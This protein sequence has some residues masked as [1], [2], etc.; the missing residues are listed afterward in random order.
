[1]CLDPAALIDGTA[2]ARKI[3]E[4]MRATGERFGVAHIV[5]VLEGKPNDK[6][7]ALRHTA[8]V[9]FGLGKDR[10]RGEWQALIRQ[11]VGGGFVSLD[12]AGFGGLSIAPKGRALLAGQ[13]EFRYRPL[14]AKTTKKAQRVARAAAA[15]GGDK[16]S[17]A[18]LL[19]L[20]ALRSKLARERRVPAYVI[21]ADR[22]LIDM[23][24]KRPLTKWDFG[25]MHGVGAAKQQ[26]FGDA[27]LAEIRDFVRESGAPA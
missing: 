10:A 9:A 17:E 16:P 7:V 13:A 25:E 26:Q 21:F 23:A 24:A 18:L 3:F 5:D 19:R 12:V 27:F 8:L 20:K 22:S 4:A 1:V 6:A 14:V 2:E 15:L 11:L